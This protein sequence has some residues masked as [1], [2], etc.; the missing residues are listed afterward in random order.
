MLRIGIVGI[1]F[2][3]KVHMMSFTDNPMIPNGRVKNAKLTAVCD[4][5]VE[6]L[7]LAK[8]TVPGI[9]VFTDFKEM[10]GSGEID[11]VIVAT[12]HYLHP[13]MGIEAIKQKIHVLVEK[14]VGV[15]TKNIEELNEISEKNK[16]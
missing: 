1:G 3:G 13:I 4:I 16:D 5:D 9:K 8:K 2:M 10:L 6:K 14:P 15:Y 12:P 11:A 7:E